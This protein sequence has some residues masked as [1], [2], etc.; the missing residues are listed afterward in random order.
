MQL[1]WKK[2][3][4]IASYAAIAWGLWTWAHPSDDNVTGNWA[5]SLMKPSHQSTRGNPLRALLSPFTPSPAAET[6]TVAPPNPTPEQAQIQAQEAA[7]TQ[8]IQITPAQPLPPTREAALKEIAVA[9]Q[10][11]REALQ[12]LTPFFEKSPATVRRAFLDGLVAVSRDRSLEGEFLGNLKGELRPAAEAYV[13]AVFQLQDQ[14]LALDG[15]NRDFLKPHQVAPSAKLEDHAQLIRSTEVSAAVQSHI[16]NSST[17]E[18][19]RDE[20]IQELVRACDKQKRC[21]EKGVLAWMDSN[22]RFN[23][24]QLAAI[25]KAVN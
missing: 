17:N 16:R 12:A 7:Q 1:M 10:A 18:S 3:G 9:E 19:I 20:D 22:H 14:Y 21:I 5:H 6:E 15:I 2:T 13:Q 11:H 8:P 4:W 25:E 23:T 24:S